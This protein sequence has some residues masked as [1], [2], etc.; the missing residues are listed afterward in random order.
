MPIVDSSFVFDFESR[1]RVL[2]TNEYARMLASL[3]FQKFTKMMT[4]ESREEVLGWLQ[5]SAF[6]EAQG[7]GGN[8]KYDD[9]SMLEQTIVNLDAGKGLRVRKQQFEDLD[10]NGVAVGTKWVQNI[11]GYGAYWPQALIMAMIKANTRHLLRR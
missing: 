9:L 2:Q 3:Y 4:S 6:I 8:V 1:L 5:D 10:G 7:L 11:S